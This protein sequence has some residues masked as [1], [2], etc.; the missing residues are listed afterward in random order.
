MSAL[1]I[2]FLLVTS[3][4]ALA[5]S[6][7]IIDG[8]QTAQP[9]D[10]GPPPAANTCPV[11]PYYTIKALKTVASPLP[12]STGITFDGS[13]L[14]VLAGGLN[15][16]TN[17]LVR[18]DPDTGT[19]DRSFSFT[20]LIEQ[21]GSGAYGIAWDVIDS[22]IWISV[23]GNTNKVVE[24]DAMTGAMLKSFGSVTAPGPT[25][26]DFDDAR[27]MFLSTG[28]GVVYEGRD[29][30]G[31]MALLVRTVPAARER[32]NGIAVRALKGELW[33]G[34]FYGGLEVYD[35]NTG[36]PKGV[37]VHDDCSPVPQDEVGPSVFVADGQT[38]EPTFVMLSQRGITYYEAKP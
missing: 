7:K 21:Q 4:L 23:S 33:V 5:C 10:S 6:G 22:S 25:D 37:V 27:A 3:S 19:I 1:R 30:S 28:L 14:W 9:P 2:A 8:G 20:N 18:F 15:A 16:V 32:D 31:A 17:T 34:N 12:N 38:S 35:R 11:A 24:V 26:L 29:F 13:R 36:A